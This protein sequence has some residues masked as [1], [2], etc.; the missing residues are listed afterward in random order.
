[1]TLTIYSWNVNGIRAVERKG[2]VDWLKQTSP[3]I[4]CLQ[5]TKAWPEQLSKALTKPEGYS[6]Y[7]DQAEKKGYS[8]TA[9]YSSY[10]PLNSVSG[11]PDKYQKKYNLVDDRDRDAGKE[12]RVVTVEYEDFYVVSVYTPNATDPLQRL[13][14]RH[15]GWDPAFLEYMK[16]LNQ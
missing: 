3:D 5:E 4:L 10:E 9:I 12:G 11:L 6:V 15:E 14:L 2:F 8:G 7:W 1:M 13:P 16:D